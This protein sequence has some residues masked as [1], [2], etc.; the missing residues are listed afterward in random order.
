MYLEN[1]LELLSSEL[2]IYKISEACIISYPIT[3]IT[4]RSHTLL[5]ITVLRSFFR[6]F[7]IFK[8]FLDKK[9]GLFIKRYAE[10]NCIFNKHLKC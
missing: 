2:I 10:I 1:L 3:Q 6:F 8:N 9:I 5:L 7:N 4:H